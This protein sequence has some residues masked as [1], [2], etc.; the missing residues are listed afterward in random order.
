MPDN[1]T[2]RQEDD[3]LREAEEYWTD[4]RM[5]E[6]E[7]IEPPPPPPPDEIRRKMEE[8]GPPGPPADAVIAPPGE[9]RG[10]LRGTPYAADSDQRPYWNCGGMFFTKPDGT[11]WR[12]SGAFVGSGRIVLTA[13]HCVRDGT[14]GAWFKNVV[15]Y[16]GYVGHW[17]GKGGQKVGVRCLGTKAAWVN[18]NN[19]NYVYDYSFCYTSDESGAGWLG[20]ALGV[21]YSSWTSA[22]YPGNYGDGK[23]MYA[24]A[25]DKGQVGGGLV[26]MLGNPF[27]GGASGGPWIGDLSNQYKPDGNMAIGVNS[28]I[29]GDGNMWGPYFDFATYDLYNY[30][31][32]NPC[33]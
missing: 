17:W 3:E 15:F 19:G 4:E 14:S 25:G 30:M 22:G 7:P 16:R 9:A 13:A 8:E 12:G 2:N 20:L 18:G 5:R 1:E 33:G 24:V 26:Q 27:E 21:P 23:D 28:F 31:L 10:R 32:G 6:A 11:D 29:Y